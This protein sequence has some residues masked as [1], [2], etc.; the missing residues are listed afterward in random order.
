MPELRALSLGWGVQSFTLA[1]MSALGELPKLDVLIHADT[2]WERQ[3]TYEFA[4][5]WQPW[6][7]SK[8]M[9]VISGCSLSARHEYRASKTNIHIPALFFNSTTG[10]SGKLNRQCTSRWKIAV[11][12]ELIR[13][14]LQIRNLGTKPG[15]VEQWLG[16]SWDEAHR[17][18]N[19]EVKYIDMRHPF[20]EKDTRMKRADC[21]KWLNEHGLEVPTKSSCTHCIFHSQ[22]NWE[23]IKRNSPA[24]WKEAVEYDLSVR[25]RSTRRGRELFIHTSLKPLTQAVFLPEEAG[26]SQS[27]LPMD[28]PG[29]DTA[30]YCWD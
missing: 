8:G 5:K 26:Y 3:A 15:I 7:E 14:E 18:K 4:A 10:K 13:Q 16:I 28:G 25:N 21:I 19:S 6:L 30:G 17:A 11:V 23:D 1:A 22:K 24:D 29:C 27:F 20:L 12:R 2:S 9:L